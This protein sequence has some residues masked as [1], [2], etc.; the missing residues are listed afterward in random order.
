M[1]FRSSKREVLMGLIGL[2]LLVVGSAIGF[3]IGNNVDDCRNATSST[4]VGS[5]R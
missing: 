3:V 1:A 4:T 2:S 5:T